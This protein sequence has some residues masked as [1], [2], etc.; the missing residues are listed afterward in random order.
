[1]RRSSVKL[2]GAIARVGMNAALDYSMSAKKPKEHPGRKA[3]CVIEKAA[4]KLQGEC[5]SCSDAKESVS[6][7]KHVINVGKLE[8]EPFIPTD[9]ND[10][11]FALAQ[12]AN[13]R[14]HPTNIMATK[15][16]PV[17]TSDCQTCKI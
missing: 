13:E 11:W 9:V 3:W 4:E 15:F 8:K 17:T 10:K 7:L 6:Y 14:A 1:M 2:I 16:E 12:K 5:S